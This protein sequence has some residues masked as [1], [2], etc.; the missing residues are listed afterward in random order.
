[1]INL[2]SKYGAEKICIWYFVTPLSHCVTWFAH[3][4][5]RESGESI[6][7]ARER[8]IWD[9]SLYHQFAEDLRIDVHPKVSVVKINAAQLLL[10]GMP[11]PVPV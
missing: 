4:E 9:Y 2:F 5:H 7:S 1:M 8:C 3:R 11:I 10:S 6:V